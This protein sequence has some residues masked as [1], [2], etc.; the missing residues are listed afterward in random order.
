MISQVNKPT[1]AYKP[2][3]TSKTTHADEQRSW[4][5]K[6][7]THGVATPYMLTDLDIIRRQCRTFRTLLPTVKLFYAMK[8]F[9]DD[10]V[11]KAVDP[12]VDGYDAASVREIDVLLRLGVDPSRIAYS[13]PVKSGISIDSAACKGVTKFAFQ[14][15]QELE[16][17]AQYAPGASVYVRVKMDDSNSVVPLSVKYGCDEDSVVSLLLHAKKLGLH[18][19]G[20]TFHVGSQQTGLKAWRSDLRKGRE[21][22]AAVRKA[23]VEVEMINMGGGFPVQYAA[24]DPEIY[25]IG[26]V[27]ND[28]I[29]DDTQTTYMAEPGRFIAAGSSVIVSS[30]IGI[31][32]RAG[33]TWLYMD[34]GVFQAFA[35]AM[36]FG[37]FPHTPYS[38]RHYQDGKETE[39]RPYV[40]AGPT[41]DSHDI[42]THEALLPNDITVG[43]RLIFSMTGAYTVVYG[44]NFNGF[45]IPK[46]IFINS[47]S[48]HK[49]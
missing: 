10:E 13:N 31:E 17:I 27:V 43:D 28:V 3:K 22:L 7:L 38:L 34:V 16:K 14:S 20:I 11:L 2:S 36:R 26:K 30:V 6:V 9:S 41:C 46:R 32:E 8:A 42:I 21:L 48:S 1:M 35:G 5:A 49:S 24:T 4:V 18:P 37:S 44:A 15:A 23:G 29:A 40:I 33:K 12:L 19:L 25:H 39:K 45:E 47:N